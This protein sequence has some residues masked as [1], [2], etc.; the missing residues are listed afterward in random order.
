MALLNSKAFP[1]TKVFQK[2]QE[3][4]A[5]R[6]PLMRGAPG[7]SNELGAAV[8]N[9]RGTLPNAEPEPPVIGR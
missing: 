7:Y 2:T 3:A 5:L 8:E 4:V 6:L 1:N 9:L